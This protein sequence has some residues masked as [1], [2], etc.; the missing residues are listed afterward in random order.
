MPGRE[1]IFQKSMNEGHS[2][3]WDQ[4]W[5]KAAAAYRRALEEFPLITLKRSTASG[6]LASSSTMWMKLLQIYMRAVKVS[7]DDPMPMEKVAQLSERVGDLKTATE[8]AVRAGDLFLKQRDTDKALE[9][10]VHVTSINRACHCPLSPCTGARTAWAWSTSRDG[11]SCHCQHFTA[12][13]QPE[14]TQEMVNKAQSL[15]PNS[16][17]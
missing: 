14:K 9:N 1:D 11:I 10:W 5:N 17:E 15:V 6:N 3:A 16:S 12:C 13:R 8:A 2:A 7:P 4:E